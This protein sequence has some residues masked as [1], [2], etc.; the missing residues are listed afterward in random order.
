MYCVPQV[1]DSIMR[2]ARETLERAIRLV[3]GD[4]AVGG[5]VVYGGHGQLVCAAPEGAPRS[6]P[7]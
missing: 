2:K 4:G 1:G 6:R 3:E 7:F 5:E